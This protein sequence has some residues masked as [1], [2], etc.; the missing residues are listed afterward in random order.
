MAFKYF[1]DICGIETDGSRDN[2]FVVNMRFHYC[3]KC[4]KDSKNWPKIH[5]IKKE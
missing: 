2:N 1:C 5:K 4:W 3:Q